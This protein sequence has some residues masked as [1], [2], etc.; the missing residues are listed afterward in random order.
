MTISAISTSQLFSRHAKNFLAALR[1]FYAVLCTSFRLCVPIFMQIGRQELYFFAFRKFEQANFTRNKVSRN[2][3]CAFVGTSF[4]GKIIFCDFAELFFAACQE[5]QYFYVFSSWFWGL[6]ITFKNL[7]DIY[8]R[9]SQ[10]YGIN[11]YYLDFIHFCFRKISK[12]KI[13]ENLCPPKLIPLR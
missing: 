10:F 4:A 11:F 6:Y 2:Y 1:N 3:L 8:F 12:N 13:R 9:N 5:N 7:Y